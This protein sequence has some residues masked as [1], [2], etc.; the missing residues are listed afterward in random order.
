MILPKCLNICIHVLGIHMQAYVASSTPI[1]QYIT[2]QKW[3]D[4]HLF[5]TYVLCITVVIIFHHIKLLKHV[6]QI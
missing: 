2:R 6:E 3:D 1:C 4:T 5:T